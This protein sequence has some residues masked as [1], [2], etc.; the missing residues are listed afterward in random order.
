MTGIRRMLVAL[1]AAVSLI[2]LASSAAL[3]AYPNSM[4]ATGDSITR[5]FNTCSFP[6]TD[7]PQNSWATGTERTVNS[8]YL[9]IRERNRGIEGRLFN[10]ARSGARM[11]DLPGQ[12]TTA[13]GQRVEYVVTEMGA[14]DVCTSEVGTMTSVASYRTN[15]ETAMRTLGERLP[16][17]ARISVGSIPNI[18]QLWSV[19]HTNGSAVSTWNS[20]GICQS[21]LRNPTSTTREDEERRLL[22]QRREV[23]FNGVLAEVCATYLNCQYDRNAGYEVRFEAGEVSTR[24]YFHP[25]VRGQATI[26]SIE[27]PTVVF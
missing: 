3:A 18:Y 14:N 17:G 9:R 20:L 26:A 24:D 2:A 6:F 22:V 19:L 21:M 7:C 15:F 11:S 4:A 5:A 27:F 16:A 10:D 8:F 25:S 13:A 23:E 1:A 12:A